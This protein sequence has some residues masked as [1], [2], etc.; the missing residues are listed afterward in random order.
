MELDGD[1]GRDAGVAYPKIY[2]QKFLSN[3]AEED[4]W[5]PIRLRL[6][7][8]SC[9]VPPSLLLVLAPNRGWSEQGPVGNLQRAVS[10][11]HSGGGQPN[12]STHTLKYGWI[13]V[14][15]NI[16]IKLFSLLRFLASYNRYRDL[17][18]PPR[19]FGFCPRRNGTAGL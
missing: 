11:A 10:C 8:I 1:T 15:Y 5:L 2:N 4:G 7:A 17:E 19:F 12:Y 6:L 18:T 3:L 13:W 16:Y 14:L 9:S